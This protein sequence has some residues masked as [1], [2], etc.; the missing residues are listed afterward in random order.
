M[1]GEIIKEDLIES[2][3][4]MWDLNKQRFSGHSYH[5][6]LLLWMWVELEHQEEYLIEVEGSP[7]EV[8]VNIVY[9]RVGAKP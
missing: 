4:D 2:L 9:D 7:W 8:E 3:K 1:F 6:R 5:C